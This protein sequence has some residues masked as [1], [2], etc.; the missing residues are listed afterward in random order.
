MRVSPVRTLVQPLTFWRRGTNSCRSAL[1]LFSREH[2]ATSPQRWSRTRSGTI[3]F[4]GWT[5]RPGSLD[6]SR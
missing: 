4:H 5:R 2:Q 1:E 3:R 6:A